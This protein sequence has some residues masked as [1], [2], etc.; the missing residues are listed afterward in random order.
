MKQD[1]QKHEDMNVGALAGVRVIELGN[2]FAGPACG[3]LLADFG[4]DVIKVEPPGGDPVRQMGKFHEGQSLLATSIQRG[5]RSIS[6]DLKKAKARD[7]LNELIK[8]AD[9]VLENNRPGVMER[10]GF[11]Y[12]TMKALNPRLVFLRISGYGQTG[13]KANEPGYGAICDA[14]AGVRHLTGDPDRAPSRV[15]LPTT[16]YLTA[17]Y[18]AFGIAMALFRR[19]FTGEGQQVDA[20]LFESAFSM[21]EGDVPAYHKLGY[22]PIRQGPNLPNVAPNSLYPTRDGYVLI[23]ANNDA[24]FSRLASLVFAGQAIDAKFQS[25]KDRGDNAAELD[26][27][28]SSWTSKLSSLEVEQ[29]LVDKAVPVSRVNTLKEIFGEPHFAARQALLEVTH[30][31]LG[32]VKQVGIAPK[33]SATPGHVRWAGHE[34]GQDTIQ[35]LRDELGYDDSFITDLLTQQVAFTHTQ[36][37]QGTMEAMA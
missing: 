24:T 26:A 27:L 17:V 4:A 21:M 32:Q 30:P 12:D 15:A 31:K 2:T 25:V 6:L 3:R 13:P 22:V 36:A 9:V 8:G 16:D 11:S 37:T 20:S 33:L 29:A 7:I 23:A 18:G 19:N 34:C 5:K 1:K 35:I 10:L 14:F 28:I